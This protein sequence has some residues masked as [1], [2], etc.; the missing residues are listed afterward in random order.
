MASPFPGMDPYLEDPAYWRDVHNRFIN[1][2]CEAIAD[3]LPDSYDAFLDESVNLVHMSDEWC[4]EVYPD[5]AVMRKRKVGH[6]K[7]KKS[8]TLVLEPVTM[9]IQYLDEYRQAYI[10]IRKRPDRK[11]IAI[12]ELLSPT[13]K[14][15]DGYKEYC[16]KRDAILRQKVH[17]VELDLLLAGKHPPFLKSLPEGDYFTFVSRANK[18]PNCDVYAWG[19]RQPL[20]TI[21][22][23]LKAPDKDVWIDLGEVL[24]ITYERGRYAKSLDYSKP[25]VA[26]LSKADARWTRTL[27]VRK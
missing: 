2:W 9:P 1:A 27:A 15:G 12:L 3:E 18:R 4:K 13:N 23:P 20:P 22:V 24:R 19:L 7:S 17:L 5:V 26:P 6:A 14:H 21:P 8:G 25:P 16:G 11:L 10:E